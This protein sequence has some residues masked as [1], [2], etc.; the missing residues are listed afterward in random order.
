M[1]NMD[2][3]EYCLGDTIRFTWKN[4]I[5]IIIIFYIIGDIMLGIRMFINK[6]IEEY[7]IEQNHIRHE[8]FLK[9]L[10]NLK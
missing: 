4:I 6:K 8:Q 2:E 10:D 3:T 7:R 5:L 1:E 9:D